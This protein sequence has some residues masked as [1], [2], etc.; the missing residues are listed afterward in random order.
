[1]H[2]CNSGGSVS[3]FA[4]AML[5]LPTWPWRTAPCVGLLIA[6]LGAG[7]P[8][9]AACVGDCNSDG[10][11]TINELITGVNIALGNA[12]VAACA[13]FDVDRNGSVAVNEVIAAVSAALGMCKADTPTPTPTATPATPTPRPSGTPPPATATR[14]PPRISGFSPHSGP[15]GTLVTITGSD[16]ASIPEFVPAVTMGKQGGGTLGAPLARFDGGSIAIT[17]PAGAATGPLTATIAGHS[18][19]TEQSF[20]VVPSSQFDLTAVPASG[21][22]IRGQ[23]AAFGIRLVSEDGFS[24][25]AEL[26]V[27][28]LPPGMTASF[29][30]PRIGAGQQAV[31]GL[32]SASDQMLGATAL[33][34]TAEARVDGL[35]VR[36]SIP[37]IVAVDPVST[38]FVGRTVVD[39]TSETPLAGITVTFL[40]RDGQGHATPCNAQTTSDEAGNF[41]FTDLPPQCT[42][43]QLIRYD[44]LTA[45]NPPGDYAG[46]DLVYTIAAGEVTASSVLVHLPR[47]DDKETVLVKQNAGRDQTFCFRT[48]PGLCATVYAGTVFTLVDGTQPDPFR[49]T[50][51]QV[52][53][54]R[55][56]DAKPFD[57]AM[58]MVFIVAFQPANTEASQPVAIT[59]PNSVNTPPSTS[60]VLMTLDPTKG[61]MVPYGTG[62]VSAD[63]NQVV[64]DLDPAY[65]GHRFG[66]VHFDWHG[67]MPPPPPVVNP[68]NPGPPGSGVCPLPLRG[69][70]IDISSGLEILRE[71]DLSI[72]GLRGSISIERVYRSFSSETGPFGIGT[73]HNYSYRLDTSAPQ[74]AA[75]V[76]LIAPDG[77]R[78]PF[79][80]IPGQAAS[81]AKAVLTIPALR[82]VGLS[83]T[84]NGQAQVRF[85]DGT[86]FSF[87]PSGPVSLLDGI[88]DA[89]GNRVSLIRDPARPVRITQIVDPV[90]RR[91]VLTYDGT[92]RITTITDPIGRV[93]TYAYNPQGTLASVVD[94]AQGVTQYEYDAQNRLTKVIDARGIAVAEIE[95]DATTGR[96][97]KQT[98]ASGGVWRFDYALFNPLA[99]TSPVRE[100][101]VTDPLGNVTVYRFNPQ[102][103]LLDV[104][105]ALGQKR[106]FER[107]PGT[108]LLVALRGSA[109]CGACGE[110]G[111]GD[112]SFT[113]DDDGNVTSETDALGNTTSLTYERVFNK[114][115]SIT[116]ALQHKTTFTYGA[117]GTLQSITDANQHTTSFTYGPFGQLTA[118][119]DPLNQ[120]THVAHD[121]F[122]NQ[123]AITDALGNT[124]RFAYDAVSRLT[125]ITDALGRSTQL[126]H[127][128]LDRVTEV[129][130]A[131][132]RAFRAKYDSVGNLLSL[133]DARDNV[134]SFE[135]DP[136]AR[137]NRRI[138][139][140][141]NMDYRRYDDAGNL[142]DSTDRRGLSSQFSY[143]VLNRLIAANYAD[144]TV[145]YAYDAGGSLAHVDDTQGGAFTFSYDLAGRQL[146]AG[147]RFGTVTYLRD[148]LGRVNVRQVVGTS[149]RTYEYDPVSNLVRATTPEAWVAIQY[150]ARSRV[151]ME[152]RSSGV[153]SRYEYDASGNLLRIV[154]KSGATILDDQV[155]TYDP[156]GNP[157]SRNS[158]IAQP[159]RTAGSRHTPSERSNEL[160]RIDDAIYEYDKAGNRTAKRSDDGVIAY[161]WD[162]RGRLQSIAG[163]AGSVSFKYD[164]LGYLVQQRFDAPPAQTITYLLDDLTNIAA[165]YSSS[166][167]SQKNTLDGRA[168]D[169]LFGFDG[170]DGQFDF[171]LG[172]SIRNVVAVVDGR[173]QP[174]SA[175]SYE[176]FGSSFGKDVTDQLVAYNQ[177]IPLTDQLYHYRS[178]VYDPTA[179]RFLSEDPLGI[180]GAVNTY[181]YVYNSPVRY[182]DAFGLLVDTSRCGTSWWCHFLWHFLDEL[183]PLSDE[184]Y[185]RGLSA[186][187]QRMHET[188]LTMSD[189][190]LGYSGPLN[191]RS[192]FLQKGVGPLMDHC[193]AIDR[194]LKRCG[195]IQPSLIT[196]AP[197]P[198]SAQ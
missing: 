49:F 112:R 194:A 50:A 158:I 198:C 105:D 15:I 149:P 95:Y 17:V 42:G 68:L 141:G 6:L 89:N 167:G 127:D 40:G 179:A 128:A 193:N 28:G 184:D 125:Q 53:V 18:V 45:T 122:G 159:L 176:P 173:G 76:N 197:V 189:V 27:A 180:R 13:S 29:T 26:S 146:S 150:D 94:P 181:Q 21:R 58:M 79:V 60:M 64:P 178:R 98:L 73:G 84:P 171:L 80:Q 101:T 124:T 147:T 133:A 96:A 151:T 14:A 145:R 22:V 99:P 143:D 165:A 23:R 90:G 130:D 54:D 192:D 156:T 185:S 33:Q 75:V 70:P 71:T 117:G 161:M 72:A 66:L 136:V 5:R 113:Y 191:H 152:S 144:A 134:I 82:G 153:E 34:V 120:H 154:H 2:A 36:R 48:I 43:E 12:V 196:A 157:I 91:L 169:R 63:G 47:I 97:I 183:R 24:Q 59:Y 16:F 155:Y 119:T 86:V 56:P 46:V 55:L 187:R 172:D 160:L 106:I 137:E 175:L 135:Y 52:P 69:K 195:T 177:R 104:T 139:S 25:L 182:T 39:D 170:G 162:A 87:V 30:P 11:V 131:Q 3:T 37:L 65:P 93:V 108:N 74:N 77:S 114:V 126:A 81:K 1:M 62:V 32:T 88:T 132:G 31:L 148:A 10:T 138:D 41:A 109:S 103:F 35:V 78:F 123:V 4:W 110:A 168:V 116:D 190:V 38:S 102:G 142:T 51:V 164:F 67:Q 8:A 111:P 44:G 9:T 129:I 115:E 57:P 163:G 19:S 107:E 100:T 188:G 61:R 121:A 20:E 83:A 118:I 140:L 7:T 174:K 166:D 85:K 92:D 186:L